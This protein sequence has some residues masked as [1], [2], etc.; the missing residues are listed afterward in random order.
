MTEKNIFVYNI[1]LPVN[2]SDFIF[3]VKMLPPWKRPPPS[4]PATPSKNWDPVK[5]PL[6]FFENL[7][8]GST[9]PAEKGVQTVLYLREIC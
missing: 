2:I 3:Y 8:G 1:L 7:V 6:P 4:F 5:P 9:S